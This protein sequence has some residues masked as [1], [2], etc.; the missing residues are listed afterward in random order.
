[1]YRF[2]NEEDLLSLGDTAELLGFSRSTIYKY[3]SQRKIDY[4]K[5][6]GRIRFKRKVVLAWIDTHRVGAVE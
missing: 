2:I 6:G 4:L 5:I 3:I 1:M